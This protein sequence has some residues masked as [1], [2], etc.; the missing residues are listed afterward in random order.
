ME[1]AATAEIS[2]TQVWQWVHH[3][4]GV[5]ADG[6]KVTLQLVRELMREELERI[7]AG[8]TQGAEHL[9]AAA[10]LFDELVA[11]DELA[12]FLTLKAYDRLETSG[13][14]A[15]LTPNGTPPHGQEPGQRNHFEKLPEATPRFGAPRG[16]P[17]EA[18][19][20]QPTAPGRPK[21][22]A[23]QHGALTNETK[24]KQH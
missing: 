21:N 13:P 4:L 14:P 3:P 20:K 15:A 2:R 1:D 7:R 9:E 23:R 19:G 22:Q 18:N 16:F 11:A 8:G 10:G 12:E 5:L 24:S 6:R 17:L